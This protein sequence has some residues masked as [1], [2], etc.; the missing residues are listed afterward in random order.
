MSNFGQTERYIRDLFSNVKEFSYDGVK[1]KVLKCGKPSPNKG[2]CKTDIYVLGENNLGNTRE[3]KIS[4]KQ[5]NADFLENKISLKRAIEIFGNDAQNIIKNALS[6]IKD[7][8]K[9][10]FLV[11]FNKYK[12]T[13]PLCM[14]MGWKFEFINKTGGERTGVIPLSEKQKMDIYAGTNLSSE[15]KN[16]LVNGEIVENS[17]IAN[18]ILNVDTCDKNLDF[19]LEKMQPIEEFAKQQNIYFACKALNFRCDEDKWDGDRPLSV[20]VEWKLDEKKNL[21]ANLVYDNPL[22]VKGNQIG[23]NIRTILK[24]L[25]IDKNNFS[26]LKKH[27]DKNIKTI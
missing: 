13:K 16:C 1:Y 26:S 22:S 5:T 3:F 14:K 24:Q 17:G 21:T 15:K 9:N 10:D 25:G 20:Y 8:F 12:R 6:L 18:F 4:V 11:Y 2:E 7:D 19:Y 27:L 23:N